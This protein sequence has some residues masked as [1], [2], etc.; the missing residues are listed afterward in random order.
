MVSTNL[1]KRCYPSRTGALKLE[2]GQLRGLIAC[3]SVAPRGPLPAGT[4][5]SG[6]NDQGPALTF[7]YAASGWA[8]LK[9]KV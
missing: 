9:A 4:S 5:G 1:I 7:D 2:Y 3:D 8:Q 6:L